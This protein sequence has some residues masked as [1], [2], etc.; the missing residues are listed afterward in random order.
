MSRDERWGTRSLTWSR[1]HR[2]TF[3]ADA[4]MIDLDAIGYCEQDGCRAPLYVIEATQDVGQTKTTTIARDTAMRLNAA[5]WLVMYTATPEEC[6]CLST[7]LLAGCRHG[8]SSMRVRRF[9]PS[10][11]PLRTVSPGAFAAVLQTIRDSH[12]ATVCASVSQLGLDL[13]DGAA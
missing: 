12:A 7:V 6:R 11:T 4:S 1:W 9:W 3:G 8:V 10:P 13:A 5:G 2:Y